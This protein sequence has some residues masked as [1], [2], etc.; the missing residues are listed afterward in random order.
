MKKAIRKI[1]IFILIILLLSAHIVILG[2]TIANALEMHNEDTN[3]KNVK[4]DAYLKTGEGK[5]YEKEANITER[6]TLVLNVKVNNQGVLRDA[7]INIGNT[8]FNIITEEIENE[9]IKQINAETN[10]IE[11]NSI[12]YSNETT[13]EIPI[14]F[15]KTSSFT[16]DYFKKDVP[17]TLTGTYINETEEA[18][19]AQRTI[20][21]NWTEELE[22]AFIQN[23][24][25]YMN[26]NDGKI[27]IQQNI[28]TAVQDNILPRESETIKTKAQQINGIYPKDVIVIAN[29]EKLKEGIN[30]DEQNGTLEIVNVK[31]KN[32]NGEIEWGNF[33]NEY[34]VIYTYETEEIAEPRE[35]N[36][37]TVVEI[38]L[39][40]RPDAIVKESKETVE[41]EAKGNLVEVTKEA[42]NNL[43]KGYM[44][45]NS[46]D[47]T[48]FTEKNTI[49]IAKASEIE[50][51]EIINPNEVFVDQNNNEYDSTTNMIYKSTTVNKNDLEKIFG[52]SYELKIVDNQ[53]NEIANI[54]N[55][56][57]SDE[58]GNITVNYGAEVNY[59][60][61]MTSKP[62][63]EGNITIQNTR[64]IK[65]NTG[66]TK[67][68]LKTINKIVLNCNVINGENTAESKTEIILNDTVTEAKMEI[69]NT[70]LSAAQ[71]NQDVQFLITLLSDSAKY[72]LYKNPVVDIVL[73]Q[74][75][76]IDVKKTAQLNFENEV[77][78]TKIGMTTREDNKKVI[79]INL[80]GEQVSFAKGT[81]GGIQVVL[82]GD[83]DVENT[84]ET[85][86]ETIQLLYSNENSANVQFNYDVPITITAK[87]EEIVESEEQA[88]AMEVMPNEQQGVAQAV[89]IN[90]DTEDLSISVLARTGDRYLQEGDTVLEGQGIKYILKVTNNTNKDMQN[91]TLEATNTNAI[92]YNYIKYQENVNGDMM[93]KV[94]LVEDE[95]LTSKV[96]EI[97]ELKAGETKEVNY[98]ISVKEIEGE[99]ENLT[100]QIKLIVDNE[101]KNTI[102]N[103]IN[104][105]EQGKLK[106]NLLYADPENEHRYTKELFR[107]ELT[108]KNISSED[109][110]DIIVELPVSD[111][112]DF[113]TK[114][115]T[116]D[117]EQGCEFIEYKDNIAKFKISKLEAGKDTKFLIALPTNSIPAE[118]TE[119]KILEYFTATNENTTYISNEIER[120]ILQG[121]A[122]IVAKQTTNIEGNTVENG[123][124]IKFIID[125]ENK[126]VVATSVYINDIIQLGLKVN[127]VKIIHNEEETEETIDNIFSKSVTMEPNDKVRIIIDTTLDSKLVDGNKI[128]NTINFSSPGLSIEANSIEFTIKGKEDKNPT[129]DPN[130]PDNPRNTNSISGLAFLD[131]NGNG[132]RES[133]EQMLPNITVMLLDEES[134]NVAEDKNGNSL[135]TV[136]N[137]RGTYEFNNLKNGKYTVAFIYDTKKYNVTQYQKE[138]VSENL[139][140]DVISVEIKLDG[141]AVKCAKTKIL[142]INDKVL[143]NIDAGFTEAKIFDLKLNKYVSK[144]TVQNNNEN[145]TISYDK[146]QLAKVEIDAKRITNSN[147]TIEYVIEVTN[148]GDVPGYVSEIVDY[149]PKDLKFSKSINSLWSQDSNGNLYTSQLE[150]EVISPG[151]TKS[152]TLVLTKAMTQN[153]TGTI[154]NKAEISKYYNEY[155]IEDIDSK[156]ANKNEKEDDMSGADVIISVK[157]GGILTYISIT[158]LAISIIGIGIYF[159]K[160]KVIIG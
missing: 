152:V 21:L 159:I 86:N 110:T 39:Y 20:R 68:Q 72:D 8:N 84:T 5:K 158:I 4:Y 155:M 87:P 50:T 130:N 61:I 153:N 88:P 11:L 114:N 57:E 160:K 74:E 7:K 103:I 23:I 143:S 67:E 36:L 124:N 43:Y 16:E 89:E 42:T 25:K 12:I 94:K 133:N 149:M 22:T 98:Q 30:Y 122:Q 145:R 141:N 75:L 19:N 33:I 96:I 60:K 80:E 119:T 69:S 146:S 40:T 34:N 104:R 111:K 144:I 3:I 131:E 54:S 2:E 97:G 78:I 127:G 157:T 105:I 29:G 27:L 26:L 99:N 65:G 38:K 134:H 58:A 41:I 70:N 6:E 85:K 93:D 132:N 82:L 81:A 126:G 17:I 108:V 52:Q 118:Q 53:N 140:S 51:I 48:T 92:Y 100:G 18:V 129:E 55:V 71:K 90:E 139:N 91:V 49:K 66:Y 135:I 35:F 101:E 28:C 137:Q 123:E 120:T 9:Y 62:Q 45:A 44:Y 63:E 64:A 102:D 32:E 154:I 47:E 1:T 148:E 95:S 56:T 107:M 79:R 31:K 73:P 142:E 128:V 109:L 115:I 59:I 156:P 150:N 13:I 15:K 147:V 138:G 37:E 121:E 151:E 113:L 10:E 77:Q 24:E 116:I 136:T 125:L 106:L 76:N 117:E 83:I 14:E 46:N 112:A